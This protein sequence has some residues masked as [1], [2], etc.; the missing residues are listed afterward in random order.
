VRCD[1]SPGKFALLGP[2]VLTPIVPDQDP[3]EMA[4]VI[5]QFELE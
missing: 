3:S 5:A 2:V 1:H 4:V